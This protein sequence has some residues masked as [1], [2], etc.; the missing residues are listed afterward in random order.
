MLESVPTIVRRDGIC[1]MLQ[2]ELDER[3]QKLFHASAQKIR[4]EIK[5]AQKV[6]VVVI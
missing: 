6:L 3:E 2:I 5:I 1:E 4:D